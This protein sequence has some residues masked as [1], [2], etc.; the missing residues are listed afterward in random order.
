LEPERQRLHARYDGRL[1]T[2]LVTDDFAPN[3]TV[4]Q[5]LGI[6]QAMAE[7]DGQDHPA[8]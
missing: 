2:K 4:Y 8:R 5:M 3:D 1:T 6:V 7:S